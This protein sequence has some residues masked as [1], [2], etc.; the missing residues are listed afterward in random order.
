MSYFMTA[1]G[2]GCKLTTAEPA[3]L[4]PVEQAQDYV[5]ELAPRLIEMDGSTL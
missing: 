3:E 2:P 4:L 5:R 1:A